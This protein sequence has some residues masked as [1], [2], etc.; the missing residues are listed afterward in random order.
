MLASNLEDARFSS[1]LGSIYW[2]P[3]QQVKP[4]DLV[5]LYTKAGINKAIKNKNSTTTY[6]Y[7]WGLDVTHNHNSNAC[8][9]ILEA[10][11]KSY[12]VPVNQ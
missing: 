1:K 6:F 11:W 4:G 9:V 12:A 8:I 10:N 2:F 3:D 5:V 7:Y